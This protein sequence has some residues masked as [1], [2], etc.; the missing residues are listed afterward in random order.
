MQTCAIGLLPSISF[1]KQ[2][3]QQVE[4]DGPADGGCTQHQRI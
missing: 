1:L 2:G 3:H 4:S